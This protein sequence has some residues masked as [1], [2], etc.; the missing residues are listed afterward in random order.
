MNAGY[1]VTIVT[2]PY[3]KSDIKASGFISKKEV[4]GIK[5]IVIDAPDSNKS[6]ILKRAFNAL[7]FALCSIYYALTLPH[8]LVLGSSGPITIGIPALASKIFRKK[9]MIFEVRDL[10]PR[11]GIEL[12]KITNPL[13]IKFSLWFESFCYKNAHCVVVCSEGIEAGVRKVSPETQTLIIPNSSDVKLFSQEGII[14]D[15]LP[16]N[17]W[18]FPLFLYIGSLG[19]MDDCSQIVKGLSQAKQLGVQFKMAFIGDGKEREKLEEMV[20]KMGLNEDV[21]FLGLIPKTEVV[22]WLKLA[23]ATFVTFMDF[24]VLH[25]SSPNKMFDSFAAGVP[26]IQS[27]GGWIKE[28]IGKHNVGWNVDPGSPES[29]AVAIKEAVEK[30]EIS[31]IKGENAKKLAQTKFSRDVLAEKYIKQIQEIIG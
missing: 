31:K 25:T 21:I 8:D 15:L 30:P 4:E 18:G 14:P 29:F 11:G 24:P 5:L 17:L 20:K 9:P 22:K 10:W 16:N 23:Q 6:G 27:T 12:G 3:Y 7:V 28:L 1:D 19:L 13:V 26:I 2:S